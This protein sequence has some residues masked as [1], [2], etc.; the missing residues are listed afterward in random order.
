MY[1]PFMALIDD[2]PFDRM[3]GGQV[4]NLTNPPDNQLFLAKT[5]PNCRSLQ[6]LLADFLPLCRRFADLVPY[7]LTT[8]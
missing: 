3:A 5:I 7:R 8:G 2:G 1:F 6:E 4:G